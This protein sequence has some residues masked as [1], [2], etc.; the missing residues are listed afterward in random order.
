MTDHKQKVILINGKEI[1]VD[2]KIADIVEKINERRISTSYSCQGSPKFRGIA[3]IVFEYPSTKAVKRIRSIAW[4]AGFEASERSSLAVYAIPGIHQEAIREIAKPQDYI[5]WNEK[6]L[7][8][9]CDIANDTLDDSGA[10]YRVAYP[11]HECAI[12]C[13]QSYVDRP[14]LPAYHK[15]KNLGGNMTVFCHGDIKFQERK[16]INARVRWTLPKTPLPTE[17]ITSLVAIGF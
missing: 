2:E 13:K 5:P 14:L 12:V 16:V 8:F 10:R 15:W 11:V 7:L 1:E 4:R 9:L 3:Y 17:L 6:F